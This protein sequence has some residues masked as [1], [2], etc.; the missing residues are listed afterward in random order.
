[1]WARFSI[2]QLM[3]SMIAL[4]VAFTCLAGAARGSHVAFGLSVSLLGLLIAAIVAA[5]AYWALYGLAVMTTT[6]N[7]RH[8]RNDPQGSAPTTSEK[9]DSQL[10]NTPLSEVQS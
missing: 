7:A 4:G 1:M 2:Q 3:L 5:V 6:T 8:S 9:T 10:N